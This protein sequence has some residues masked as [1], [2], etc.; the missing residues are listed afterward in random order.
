MKRWVRFT[1]TMEA[2][3]FCDPETDDSVRQVLVRLPSLESALAPGDLVDEMSCRTVA[4][5]VERPGRP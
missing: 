1:A 3:V 4:A 5:A 2:L